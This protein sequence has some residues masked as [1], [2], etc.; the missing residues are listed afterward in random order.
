MMR[1]ANYLTAYNDYFWQWED[2]AQVVS[3]VEGNT[4]AYSDYLAQL[5]GHLR[6]QGLPLFGSLLLVVIATNP[7]AH[8][9]LDKVMAFMREKHPDFAETEEFKGALRFL[10]IL[11]EMPRVYQSGPNRILLIQTV[12]QKAHN[13]VSSYNSHSIWS[14]CYEP[15][16]LMQPMDFSDALMR[17]E[18]A[19]LQIQG[20]RI[21]TV[22][23]L[24]KLI[25]GLPVVDE[26]KVNLEEV[27]VDAVEPKPYLEQLLE[28]ERTF[29]AA[30]L[31]KRIW[32]GLDIPFKQ[33]VASDQPIGGVSDLT[34]KGQFDKLLTSEFANDDL[35]FLS[36]LANNE[37]LYINREVP[38]EQNK[39]ERVLLI[40]ASLKNWG[41]PKIMAH[42][43][44]IAI[45]KHP[46]SQFDY[47][48]Y[49]IG[50]NCQP[51]RIETTEDVVRALSVLETSIDAAEGLEAFFKEYAPGL[52]QQVMYIGAEEAMQSTAFQKAFSEYRN[53]IQFVISTYLNGLVRLQKNTGKSLKH[54]NDFE[55][56]LDELWNQKRPARSREATR[57]NDLS[58][59]IP[60]I[61]LPRPP[62]SRVTLYSEDGEIFK[63][64][65]NGHI[66]RLYAKDLRDQQQGWEEIGQGLN[67][68]KGE[69]EIGRNKDGELILLVCVPTAKEVRLFNLESHEVKKLDFKQFKPGTV[70]HN[71]WQNKT[72]IFHNGV[73]HHHNFKGRWAI[74]PDGDCHDTIGNPNSLRSEDIARR[75][76]LAKGTVRDNNSQSVLKNIVGVCISDQQNLL[77]DKHEL[78]L[79]QDDSIRLEARTSMNTKLCARRL[80]ENSLQFA[81]GSK[82]Y[83]GKQ[84][85]IIL[86]SSNEMIPDIHLPSLLK[87]KLGLAAGSEFTGNPFYRKDMMYDL[88]LDD[89]GGQK[90]NVV[91]IIKAGLHWGLRE[92][93]E[94]VDR[95][96]HVA[97]LPWNVA[98]RVNNELK[99][100]GAQARIEESE[101][102]PQGATRFA[103]VSGKKFYVQY[104]STFINHI[105][106][107]AT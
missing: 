65:N 46:K 86:Q 73:F 7:N 36:R 26:Q 82:V 90:L 59:P 4:V 22:W 16:T 85:F 38:P 69:Y 19:V 13:L 41:R 54:I 97:R 78:V 3:I 107:H 92:A 71:Q 80:S 21:R 45:A 47:S 15:Q 60:R 14:H 1:S 58:E 12:F 6:P 64:T 39:H 77:F 27:Q 8:E 74:T 30:A 100:K 9:D 28:D 84:G 96:G 81:D 106:N 87:K 63:I 50:N 35:T 55:L 52:K 17:R 49:A 89:P 2:E 32:S 102:N 76:A 105:L 66:L 20:R 18:F 72:F 95:Q 93:K 75:M 62:K 67:P 44:A 104:I 43:I 56:D 94:A 10:K 48:C 33:N 42:A 5:V 29:P 11:A 24:E 51:I 99:Y 98:S 103:I 70:W 40:D 68:P 57:V 53:G 25:Q 61:L 79:K 34:N 83:T 91:K 101:G 88:Y 23:Q 31:V 37:A